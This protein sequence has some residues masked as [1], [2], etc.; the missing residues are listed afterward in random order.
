VTYKGI[1]ASFAAVIVLSGGTAHAAASSTALVSSVAPGISANGW[2]SY[3][4]ASAN[5]R[6]VAFASTASNISASDGASNLDVFVRD[7]AARRTTFV[8][9]SY[10]GGNS[11]G[12]STA[13]S[14]SA[15]GRMVA[16]ESTSATL[17][18][19]DANG[20]SDVFVK[21]LRT[22]AVVRASVASDGAEAHGASGQASISANGRYVAFQS[23]APDLVPGDDNA[24]SDV[25]VR[26]LV[27]GTTERVSVSSAGAQASDWSLYPSISADGRAIS[28]DSAAPDLVSGDT[29]GT[30]DVFVRDRAAGT[31]VRVSVAPDGAQSNGWSFYSSISANGNAVAFYSEA[32]NLAS[33]DTNA[34][35][36]VFV[37]DLAAAKTERVSVATGGA[38]GD[39]AS[40]WPSISADGSVVAFD[41]A[42]TNLDANDLNRSWDVFV[43]DRAR[44]TTVR[45]SVSSRGIMGLLDSVLPA[46]SADGRSVAF[47]SEAPNLAGVDLNATGDVFSRRL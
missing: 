36:D 42:A 32:S 37:R 6:Y 26:D 20:T 29:N 2:S 12:D 23:A 21:D 5:G 43:R 41:S 16:F 22:G 46:I 28:F 35:G 24:V 9:S 40:G 10:L 30:A 19:G 15:N 7:V 33:G 27:A 4:S 17:V 38:Q 11:G 3:A 1:A 14:I 34:A 25:F 8:S 39:L 44:G 13:P 45:A 18:P 47:T 31:T